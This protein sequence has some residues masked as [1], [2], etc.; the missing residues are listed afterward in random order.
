MPKVFINRA[1]SIKTTR[2]SYTPELE[3]IVICLWGRTLLPRGAGIKKRNKI[4]FG[5]IYG[6]KGVV[7]VGPRFG[8]TWRRQK[9]VFEPRAKPVKLSARLSNGSF[10]DEWLIIFGD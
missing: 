6:G 7:A 2:R 4:Y 3:Y 8:K 1:A 10:D 5:G 9:N